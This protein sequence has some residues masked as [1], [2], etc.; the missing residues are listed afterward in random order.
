[1]NYKL[2]YA[3]A[4][5]LVELPLDVSLQLGDKELTVRYSKQTIKI[6]YKKSSESCILFKN[7]K[8]CYKCN[9]RKLYCPNCIIETV[10]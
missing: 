7:T 6:I 5:S 10:C 8:C 2:F 1:M 9:Y 4:V 3:C